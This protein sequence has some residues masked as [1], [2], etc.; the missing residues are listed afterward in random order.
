MPGSGVGPSVFRMTASTRG[1]STGDEVEPGRQ[2]VG[3]WA[4]CGIA[5][6]AARFIPVPL[7]DD[8]VRLRATR[9]AVVRTLRANGREYPSDAVEA[10]YAGADAGATG[11]LREALRYLRSIPRRVLLFPVRKYVALF[12]AVKGVPTDVMQVLLLSRTVHRCLG[13]GRL[14]G[15]DKKALRREAVQIRIAF[16]QA[17]DG[18]DL[19]LLTGALA[20][21]L[22]QG[23]GLTRAAVGYARRGLG[24]DGTEPDLQPG[25]EVGEG[26]ERVEEVLRRPEITRLMQEFDARFD[27]RLAKN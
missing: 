21:G 16:D 15:S 12:G 22:S 6:A 19:R 14:A 26:A 13:Q 8:A 24:R 17:L 25:G 11:K 23:K 5:A 10:L 9:I 27:A 1:G 3:Q 2:L 18:M 20:D 4:V 7:L